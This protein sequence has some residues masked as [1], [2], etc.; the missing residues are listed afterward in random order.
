MRALAG[1]C[2]EPEAAGGD[3]GVAGLIASVQDSPK[4]GP[5]ATAAPKAAPGAERR[6]RLFN[7][8]NLDGW[9]TFL[10]KHGKN[11]DPGRVITI[12]DGM[13][14]LYKHAADGSEVVMGYIAT[15]KEYGN[16]HLRFQYRWGD[17]KF[18]PRYQLKRDAGLYYHI[19]GQD[20]VW[21]TA[22]QFQIEQTDVGDLLALHGY[23]VD[24][25]IDPTTKNDK[26]ATFRDPVNGGELRVLGGGGIGYQ[27]RLPGPFEKEGWNSVEIVVRGD[28][29]A[30]ILNGHVVNRG[31]NIRYADP[32]VPGSIRPISRGRIALEIE[33]AEIYFRAVEIHVAE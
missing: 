15:I 20:A 3:R 16:Y 24:T 11:R 31:R 9:Y 23:M 25:W 19:I 32:K 12:E 29:T 17:K 4:A 30:H 5:D 14:H 6:V 26:Q 27:K 2:F 8:Q 22:L 28:T 13:I 7:G 1:V 18:Q 21:P 33:A 10:Q